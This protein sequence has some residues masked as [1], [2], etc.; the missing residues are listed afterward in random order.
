[1]RID[2]GMQS[3]PEVTLP[4]NNMASFPSSSCCLFPAY[5]E[6]RYSQFRY[7]VDGYGNVVVD[8]S[9]ATTDSFINNMKKLVVRL[10]KRE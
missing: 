4:T 8:T 7:T 6:T 2:E 5:L 3:I 1:M 9:W 10:E